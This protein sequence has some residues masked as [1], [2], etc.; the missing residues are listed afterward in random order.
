M[1][2]VSSDKELDNFRKTREGYIYSDYDGTQGSG[3]YNKLH[4]AGCTTCFTMTAEVEG[5][6]FNKYYFHTIGEAIR[7]LQ[8]NRRGKWVLCE[9]KSDPI[10]VPGAVLT[11]GQ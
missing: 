6:G 10:N 9:S 3:Q 11:N 8:Q 4:S 5:I 7:W 1:I 2:K